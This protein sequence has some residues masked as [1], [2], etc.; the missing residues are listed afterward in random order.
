MKVFLAILICIVL[1]QN[2]QCQNNEWEILAK[3][4][5]QNKIKIRWACHSMEGV[6]QIKKNRITLHRFIIS[7][8]GTVSSAKEYPI[9]IDTS[10]SESKDTQTAILY[11][12]MFK[13]IQTTVSI[14]GY[15]NLYDQEQEQKNRL[16]LI[17]NI[18]S[19]NFP[20]SIAYG[21]G[22]EDECDANLVYYELRADS[23]K[24][25]GTFLNRDMQKQNE[26]IP[27]WSSKE[28]LGRIELTWQKP[29]LIYTIPNWLIDKSTDSSFTDF[30][31]KLYRPIDEDEIVYLD[32]TL[33]IETTYYYRLKGIDIFGDTS[34][35]SETLSVIRRPVPTLSQPMYLMNSHYED[36]NTLN[37][38]W[39]YASSGDAAYIKV[40]EKNALDKS[41]Q[42]LWQGNIQDTSCKVIQ[43]Y[44]KSFL[45]VCA[46]S[47]ENDSL[48]SMEHYVYKMD[49]ITP[50]AIE[51]ISHE[52]LNTRQLKVKWYYENQAAMGFSIYKSYC[53]FT[54]P[55]SISDSILNKQYI[56]DQIPEHLIADSVYYY[57]V[58]ISQNYARGDWP[59]AFGIKIVKE[60][61]PISPVLMDYSLNKDT[62]SIS[63]Y[64]DAPLSNDSIIL[65]GRGPNSFRKAEKII[66]H[67][68]VLHYPINRSGNWKFELCHMRENGE[69]SDTIQWFWHIEQEV[70]EEITLECLAIKEESKI[71]AEIKGHDDSECEILIYKKIGNDPYLL[72]LKNHSPEYQFEDSMLKIGA[73]YFYRVQLIQLNQDPIW[74]DACSVQY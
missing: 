8:S 67:E 15:T 4:V 42:V 50:T 1:N 66:A 24:L 61:K 41:Y 69:S 57:I 62:I 26:F 22:L 27:E 28:K 25:A 11:T 2:G 49:T 10:H 18:C 54:E 34:K 37:L 31:R 51:K 55:I 58:P 13:P 36:T 56:V 9:K 5:A 21:L 53:R 35:S 3:P 12:L 16:F 48:C 43:T 64:C 60:F 39:S 52:W 74:S 73:Q 40:I 23:T 71:K 65:L 68:M 46:Y 6:D 47:S 33:S 44:T 32:S 30:S 7:E 70:E 17:L 63:I 72:L 20:L 45:Q 29:D 19:N 59:K 14:N 38:K